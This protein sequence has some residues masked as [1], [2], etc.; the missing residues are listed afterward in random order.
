M[1]IL[2]I[3]EKNRIRLLALMGTAI[4]VSAIIV[5]ATDSV[6]TVGRYLTI[7]LE[8]S[9]LLGR[10]LYYKDAIFQILRQQ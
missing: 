9:T 4:L 1:K 10:V 8:S 2:K 7:S 3:S 6:Q 5:I